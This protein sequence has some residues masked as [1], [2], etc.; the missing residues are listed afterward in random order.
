MR[1]E[2]CQ[3]S[4]KDILLEIPGFPITIFL[5]YIFARYKLSAKILKIA[6]VTVLFG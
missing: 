2:R 4:M 1:E 3:Y 6:G 5:D